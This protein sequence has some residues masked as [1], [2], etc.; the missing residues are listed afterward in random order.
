MLQTYFISDGIAVKI[1]K[2]HAPL[3]R[4][5]QL[6][7]GHHQK[8]VLLLTL[9][10][11][12]EK[13]LH[14]RF[15]ALRINREWFQFSAEIQH[16]IADPSTSNAEKRKQPVPPIPVDKVPSKTKLF[17]SDLVA[18]FDSLGGRVYHFLGKKRRY[19]SSVKKGIYRFQPD[20]RYLIPPM[21]IDARTET[22]TL[23]NYYA[24]NKEL[25]NRAKALRPVTPKL[26]DLE[27][28]LD[29]IDALSLPS[30]AEIFSAINQWCR[31]IE[32]CDTPE[33]DL[34]FNRRYYSIKISPVFHRISEGKVEVERGEAP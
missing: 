34:A 4:M 20:D 28:Y 21:M 32:I 26:D 13:E 31:L 7:T 12:R 29:E 33:A 24:A 27:A 1:G 16:F 9:Q 11:N 23:T 15:S 22:Y 6:Q 18:R 19:A 5:S 14:D 2:S 30:K 25:L 8:L 3:K 10:G 17:A